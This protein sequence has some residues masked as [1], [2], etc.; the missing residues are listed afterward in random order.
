MAGLEETRAAMTVVIMA[1]ASEVVALEAAA[2]A[3]AM[4]VMWGVLKGAAKAVALMAVVATAAVM[5]AVA[6]V[7]EMALAMAALMAALV[8]VARR[9][10][11]PGSRSPG[12]MTGHSRANCA[13]QGTSESRRPRGYCCKG[14][15]SLPALTAVAVAVVAGE[16]AV[17][18]RV[19]GGAEAAVTAVALVAVATQVEGAAEAAVT[20]VGLAAVVEA[21]VETL[22]APSVAMGA[23]GRR[24]SSPCSRN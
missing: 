21:M 7:V 9:S 17:V 15:S 8:A 16:A 6:K 10:S 14:W 23:G 19:E 1:A 3:A 12:T 22:A 2:M 13:R 24:N 4:V 11:S 20:A 18:A 5:S